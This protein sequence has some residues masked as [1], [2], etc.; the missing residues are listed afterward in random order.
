MKNLLFISAAIAYIGGML[1]AWYLLRYLFKR[2]ATAENRKLV[3]RI[4]G[5][6]GAAAILP[7]S[8]VAALVG[9]NIGGGIAA[10]AGTYGVIGGIFI[11]IFLIMFIGIVLPAM[12]A[13]YLVSRF[14]PAQ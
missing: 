8:I 3:N 11:S 2:I 4:G 1:G 7:V 13:G 10:G 5:A 9:G 14:N 12:I 6:V